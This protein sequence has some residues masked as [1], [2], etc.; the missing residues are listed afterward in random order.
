[1][2]AGTQEIFPVQ[3]FRAKTRV[4]ERADRGNEPGRWQD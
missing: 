2:Q 1:M 4:T 3:V